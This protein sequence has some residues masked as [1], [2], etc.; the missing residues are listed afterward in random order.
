MCNISITF[1]IV[2]TLYIFFSILFGFY[3]VRKYIK[4]DPDISYFK[5]SFIVII[6]S[7]LMPL[8]II[9]LLYL[10]DKYDY[11]E[12]PLRYKEDKILRILI[13]FLYYLP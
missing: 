12:I 3:S 6:N 9:H 11:M 2:I 5:I 4:M 10:M 13:K 7:I 8:A 1:A